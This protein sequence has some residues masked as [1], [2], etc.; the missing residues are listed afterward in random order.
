MLITD[1]L[2]PGSSQAEADD[3]KPKERCSRLDRMRFLVFQFSSLSSRLSVLV[4]QFSSFSSQRLL[5]RHRSLHSPYLPELVP[6][7]HS[8]QVL[9]QVQDR[10]SLVVHSHVRRVRLPSLH[11]LALLVF[12]LLRPHQHRLC[13]RAQSRDTPRLKAFAVRFWKRVI[14]LGLQGSFRFSVGGQSLIFQI[15]VQDLALRACVT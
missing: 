13:S 1:R 10:V 7:R 6:P 5:T 9:L 11:Q 12:D 3:R 8:A 14:C 4:F 15:W 2:L